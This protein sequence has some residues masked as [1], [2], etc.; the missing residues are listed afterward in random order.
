MHFRF[1]RWS[2][3]RDLCVWY[4]T[5]PLALLGAAFGVSLSLFRRSSPACD[6]TR[7]RFPAGSIP[8][9]LFIKKATQTVALSL[10]G[11]NGGIWTRGHTPP[12]RVRYQAALHSVSLLPTFLP[13]FFWFC[14]NYFLFRLPFFAPCTLSCLFTTVLPLTLLRSFADISAKI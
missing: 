5:Y 13:D 10:N 7:T 2:E 9:R 8:A 12:R 11:R 14:K 6:C 1:S 4:H 3:W